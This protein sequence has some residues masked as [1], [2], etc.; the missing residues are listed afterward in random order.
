MKRIL[1]AYDVHLTSREPHGS[2]KLF[3]KFAKDFAPDEIVLG[4][5][6][7]DCEALSHWSKDKRRKIE[8]KRW[9]KE[10]DVANRE[11]DYLQK[12][13]SKIT[14]LAGNHED[15]VEQYVDAS[16]EMEELIEIPIK[17]NL[18]DRHIE[19][20]PYNELYQLGELYAT[21]GM[22]TPKYHANK[23]LVSLGCNIVYGHTHRPQMDMMNMKMSKPHKAW[24]MGC[25]CGHEPDYMRGKPSNW[26]NGFGV[27]YLNEKTGVFNLYPVDI[28]N[29]SFMF[30]GRTWK[31]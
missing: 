9:R 14:Y 7:M 19:Y 11:L 22:Y 26:M 6:F 4:G 5:D 8:G 20:L 28:I 31:F 13:S 29:N 25:L 16:P 30:E 15:W 3:K 17:L 21:H 18:F 12:H 10:L 27:V 23:H 1:L 24:C 2:Y